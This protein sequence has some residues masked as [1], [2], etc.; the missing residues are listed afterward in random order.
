MARRNAL[1]LL[2]GLLVACPSISGG[3]AKERE[4][5]QGTWRFVKFTDAAGKTQ[6]KRTG[7]GILF[8]GERIAFV[9]GDNK[10]TVQG[11]YQIDA[12]KTPKTMDIIL[13]KD[14]KKLVT[15]TIYEISGNT[16]KICHYLGKKAADE[17]PTEFVADKQTVLGILERDKE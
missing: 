17:R 15:Q 16:L 10:P 11:T 8:K 12:G 2:A 4:R 1:L 14:G 7:F 5:L 6:E 13:D 3:D 9:T